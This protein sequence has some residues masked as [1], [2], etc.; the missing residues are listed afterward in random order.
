MGSPGGA[1]GKETEGIRVRSF[2]QEDPLEEKWEPAPVLAWR[3]P[4]TEDTTEP[5]SIHFLRVCNKGDA[6]WNTFRLNEVNHKMGDLR[7]RAFL[8]CFEFIHF[9]FRD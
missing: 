1:S 3:I 7:Q 9:S 4:W 6:F 8:K 2:V 5:V